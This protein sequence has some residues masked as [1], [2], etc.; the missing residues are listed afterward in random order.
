MLHILGSIG[1]EEAFRGENGI[2][3]Y[4]GYIRLID[5]VFSRKDSQAWDSYMLKSGATTGRVAMVRRMSVQHM[6]ALRTYEAILT[7]SGC[8]YAHGLQRIFQRQFSCFE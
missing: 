2:R 1:I 4:R 6:V 5:D 8:V 7:W 3:F